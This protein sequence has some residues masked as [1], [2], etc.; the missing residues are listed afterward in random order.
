MIPGSDLLA[1]AL[2]LIA[3][4]TVSYFSFK[5]RSTN[6][7]GLEETLYNPPILIDGSLQPVPRKFYEMYGLDFEKSYYIFYTSMKVLD[8]QR[9]VSGDQIVFN[10]QQ[11]QCLSNNDWFAVDGWVGV[12]CVLVNSDN[13]EVFGMEKFNQNFEQGNFDVG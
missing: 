5:S 9:G 10:K 1:E 8:I 3:P 2:T 13:L 11:F 12:L 6:A 7:I 4:Q